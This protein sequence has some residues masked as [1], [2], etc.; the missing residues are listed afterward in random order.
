MKKFLALSLAVLCVCCLWACG[1]TAQENQQKLNEIQNQLNENA[2]AQNGAAT[3]GVDAAQSS[4]SAASTPS[5]S[6]NV[7]TA[8]AADSPGQ[9]GSFLTRLL[10]GEAEEK[11]PPRYTMAFVQSSMRTEWREWYRANTNTVQAAAGAGN[12]E[13]FTSDATNSL[14]LQLAAMDQY[15]TMTD[16]KCKVVAISPLPAEESYWREVLLDFQANGVHAIIVNQPVNVDASLYSA[17]VGPDYADQGTKAGEWLLNALGAEAEGLRIAVLCGLEGDA[18]VESRQSSF[19]D[20][21]K[22]AAGESVAFRKVYGDDTAAGGKQSMETLLQEETEGIDVVFAHNDEM[23]IGA[24]EAINETEDLKSGVDV[25]VISVGAS[26][27][28]L[29]AI[30]TGTMNASVECSPD[31]GGRVVEVAD[32]LVAGQT[33]PQDNYLETKIFDGEN[34]KDVYSTRLY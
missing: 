5:P 27:K 32:K 28:A 25:M 22:G 1:N 26:K 18:V 19:E 3:E 14:T 15:A 34:V 24:I 10:G 11:T 4:Q 33:V 17:Y 29:D 20:A 16:P 13:L 30:L 9:G 23:A 2:A 12:I 8:T 31:I 21:V 7:Q 6:E